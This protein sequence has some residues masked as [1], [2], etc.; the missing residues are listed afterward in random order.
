MKLLAEFN[1]ETMLKAKHNDKVK[2]LR[3]ALNSIRFYLPQHRRSNAIARSRL[4][5]L[6]RIAKRLKYELNL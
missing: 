5:S 6:L 3:G 4:H 2:F 1:Y